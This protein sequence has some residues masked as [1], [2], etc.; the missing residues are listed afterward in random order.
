MRTTAQNSAHLCSIVDIK[1]APSLSLACQ[2]SLWMPPNKI[3]RTLSIKKNN[4]IMLM[5]QNFP[6]IFYS[7]Q[8]HIYSWGIKGLDKTVIYGTKLP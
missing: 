8:Q 4:E 3:T 5:Q 6:I 7:I 2:R 1:T